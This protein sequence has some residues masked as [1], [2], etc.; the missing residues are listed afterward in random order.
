[1]C[2]HYKRPRHNI[3]GAETTRKV[4]CQP[5]DYICPLNLPKGYV[6][7]N[8]HFIIPE[9]NSTWWNE[10]NAELRFVSAAAKGQRT[11]SLRGSSNTVDSRK[12]IH[13]WGKG[14]FQCLHAKVPPM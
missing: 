3:T 2:G 7:V 1:M 12:G 8:S 13:T 4:G 6:W 5:G 9:G 10:R 11:V 14:P